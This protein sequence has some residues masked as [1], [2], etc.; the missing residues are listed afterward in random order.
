MISLYI[1]ENGRLES[2][3]KTLKFVSAEGKENRIVPI[4][5]IR[6]INI[7]AKVSLSSWA[8]DAI[9]KKEYQCISTLPAI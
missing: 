3:R 9:L 5:S 8:I 4:K 7:L 2:D 6:D 1:T